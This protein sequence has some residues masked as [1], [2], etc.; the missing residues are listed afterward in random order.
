MFKTYKFP[1]KKGVLGVH[2]VS[3]A[4]HGVGVGEAEGVAELGGVGEVGA[5]VLERVPVHHEGVGAHVGRPPHSV[6]Q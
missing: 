2:V 1:N 4:L 5:V 3:Q 6:L